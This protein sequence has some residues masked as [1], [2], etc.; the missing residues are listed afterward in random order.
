[1]RRS[2]MVGSMAGNSTSSAAALKGTVWYLVWALLG[3]SVLA[4]S[5]PSLPA[6]LWPAT[7]VAKTRFLQDPSAAK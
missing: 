1:M 3:L 5:L 7:W 2:Q 6:T 4:P